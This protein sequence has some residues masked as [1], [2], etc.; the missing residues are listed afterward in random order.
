MKRISTV[1]TCSF[2]FV[3]C[4]SMSQCFK[5]D[6]PGPS[7]T[8]HGIVKDYQTGDPIP[9]LNLE[10]QRST[11]NGTILFPLGSPG[12]TTTDFDIVTT[13]ADGTYT[14]TFTPIG[15]GTFSL[16]IK[17]QQGTTFVY[18]YNQNTYNELDLG[19]DN[20]VDF[21]VQKLINATIH[22]KNLSNQNKSNFRLTVTGCCNN[23]YYTF[24]TYY[25]SPIVIDTII[26]TRFPQVYTMN[27]NNM[28]Y[29]VVPNGR[30][31]TMKDTS[32][33]NKS[34]KTNRNDTTFNLIN[35]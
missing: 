13:K 17:D 11:S 35:P 9:G 20:K 22:L 23:P 15:S 34:F 16:L 14:L 1:L 21:L 32:S 30:L 6:T 28:Y 27:L 2:V 4:C 5:N 3:L 8:V 26:H 29:N 24:G 19:K 25:A 18:N 33:F 12:S 10:I 31:L 7:T